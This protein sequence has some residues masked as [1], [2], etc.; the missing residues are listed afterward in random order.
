MMEPSFAEHAAERLGPLDSAFLYGETADHPLHIGAL[1]LFDAGP[2]TAADGTFLYE[3]VCASVGSRLH[4]VPRLRQRVVAVPFGVGRPVWVD[5]AGFDVHRHLRRAALP[6]PGGWDQLLDLVGEL[7]ARPLERDRPLWELWFVEGVAGGRI[8]VVPKI[9][10]SL[11]DGVSLVDLALV[12][13]DPV[14]DVAVPDPPLPQWRPAPAPSGVQRVWQAVADAAREA[15]DAAHGAVERVRDPAATLGDGAALVRTLRSAVH[16]TAP[17]RVKGRVGP[18]RQ[19]R[20]AS[21]S[22]DVVRRA[23]RAHGV[24]LNDVVL[25]AVADGLREQL[26]TPGLPTRNRNPRAVVPVS[27]RGADER[28]G[29][30]GNKV[31]L[32][33]PELAVHVADPA[34]RLALVNAEMSTRKAESEARH[35]SAVLDAARYLPPAGLRAAALGLM[36]TQPF[37]SV[38]VTNVP[39]PTFPLYLRGARMF[40]LYPYLGPLGG[41]GIVVAVASYDGH[42]AITVTGDPDLTGDLT[43]FAEGMEKGIH[44]LT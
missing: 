28:G 41:M 10:H 42:L 3:E 8:G 18:H 15:A 14:S 34:E 12:L 31:S 25:C 20:T 13:L 27:M 4:R 17:M 6:S 40:E 7:Q 30:L 39:G 21:V 36:R 38:L 1:C 9:H 43:A 11:G 29:L 35:T 26:G 2:L 24:T 23:R 32:L 37:A 5:D 44:A 16:F 33:L 19:V 22:L